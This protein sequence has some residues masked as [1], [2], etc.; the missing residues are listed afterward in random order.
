LLSSGAFFF[1]SGRFAEPTLAEFG[2]RLVRYFPL[3]LEGVALYLAA[4]VIVY[5]A[6]AALA[7]RRAGHAHG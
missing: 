7:G 2:A 1:F 5:A 6:F 3:A 4:A